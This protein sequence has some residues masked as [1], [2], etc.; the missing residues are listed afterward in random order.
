M[1]N[2]RTSPLCSCKNLPPYCFH[3]AFAPSFIWRRHPCRWPG[4]PVTVQN[5]GDLATFATL[6]IHCGGWILNIYTPV[7]TRTQGINLSWMLFGHQCSN[8][9]DVYVIWTLLVFFNNLLL[10][11]LLCFFW[12]VDPLICCSKLFCNSLEASQHTQC[13]KIF[14]DATSCLRCPNYMHLP[15]T[16]SIG[17]RRRLRVVYF[18]APQC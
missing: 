8:N 2:L 12:C 18:R 10:K 7:C 15:Y 13:Q 14:K 16:T 5:F 4:F 1:N 11:I 3:A 6:L 9:I 17:L